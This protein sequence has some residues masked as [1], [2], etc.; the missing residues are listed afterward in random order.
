MPIAIIKTIPYW[1]GS[2]P[3]FTAMGKSRGP[4]IRRAGTPSSRPPII[5][6]VAIVANMKIHGA[7]PSPPRMAPI[8]SGTFATVRVNENVIAVVTIKRTSHSSWWCQ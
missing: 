7:F 3:S 1:S 4:K 5:I 2:I 6:R 8:L